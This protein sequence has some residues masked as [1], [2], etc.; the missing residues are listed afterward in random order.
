VAKSALIA[1]FVNCLVKNLLERIQCHSFGQPN[2]ASQA[3][4]TRKLAG[5]LHPWSCLTFSSI[6]WGGEKWKNKATRVSNHWTFH[7]V[8]LSVLWHTRVPRVADLS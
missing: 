5:S 3:S 1:R 8:W 7:Y 4:N 6:W 2:H